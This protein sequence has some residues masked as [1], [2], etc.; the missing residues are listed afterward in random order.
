MAATLTPALIRSAFDV[1]ARIYGSHGS[2]YVDY[3]GS[4]GT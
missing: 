3:V 2:V 1:D 4:S